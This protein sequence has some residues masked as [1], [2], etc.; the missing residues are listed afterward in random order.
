MT[1][2]SSR[3]AWTRAIHFFTA[4][5]RRNSWRGYYSNRAAGRT[6]RLLRRSTIFARAAKRR[7]SRSAKMRAWCLATCTRALSCRSD[8]AS[9]PTVCHDRLRRSSRARRRQHR[10]VDRARGPFLR[11]VPCQ[12]HEC[13]SL[14]PPPPPRPLLCRPSERSL[15][16]RRPKMACLPTFK[17]PRRPQRA[18]L[19]AFHLTSHQPASLRLP[20]L[21]HR[22]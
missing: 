16:L 4:T 15:L 3:R 14:L 18:R 22:T 12:W 19:R 7:M 5:L 6:S 8:P 11:V 9:R 21:C 1:G 2:L 10:H 20:L 17:R 13:L